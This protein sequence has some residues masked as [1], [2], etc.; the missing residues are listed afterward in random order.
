[1]MNRT[2]LQDKPRFPVLLFLVVFSI[3]ILSVPALAFADTNGPSFT[4][5]FPQGGAVIKSGRVTIALTAVDPDFIDYNSV[6]MLLD[7]NLVNPIKQYGWI[8]EYTD[9]Y[10]TL[11]I[12]YPASL[13]EGSHFVSVTVRD[14]AGNSSTKQW[15][16]I[17]SEPPQISPIQPEGNATVTELKPLIS[18]KVTDNTAVDSGSVEMYLDGTRVNAVFN[19]ASG[20]INFTPENELPNESWHTVLVKARDTAGNQAQ[21]SWK[22]FINTYTEMTFSMNDATCQQCHART[23]H[24]MNNCGKCHGTNLSLSNPTYPL[25]DCYKCHFNATTYPSAYHNQGLPVA[26]P[27][28]HGAQDTDSCMECHGKTWTT[29][30]PPVHSIS[31]VS[32]RHTT[33]SQ[34]CTMC[35]ATT[36]TREHVRRY[37]GNGNQLTCFTCHNNPDPQVQKAIAEKNSA[38]SACHLNLD[39]GGGHPAHQNGLDAAC[40]TCHSNTILGEQQ[41]HQA[42]GCNICHQ[43]DA[44]ETVKYAINTKNTN[45]LACHDQGH[46]LH[47]IAK[48]P[49]DLPKYPG[50]TWSVPQKASIMAGEAWM[51]AEYAGV[52]GKLL[53]SSRRSDVSAGEL[54]NWYEEQMA[55]AGWEKVSGN[56]AP[57]NYMVMS[58]QKGN[59]HATV[60]IYNGEYHSAQA[61]A[62]GFRIEILYK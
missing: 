44:G 51:P 47:M 37:D 26:N 25:D 10:S 58:Y 46:N 45:C 30:I 57:G 20:V 13:V 40:Q 21:F 27:P 60:I 14:R 9:D 43:K 32:R 38:C 48:E 29:G 6:V 1:M 28:L 41:F 53:I 18:A 3:F 34:G 39:A 52:G 62:I 55:Q 50:F 19:A 15:N 36:L 31:D 56:I 49:A 2:S 61:P 7:G 5:L 17:I 33:T 22:F 8:D 11:E 12:Y 23:S 24:P 42:K 54:F 35:H 16:F 59:R 4:N